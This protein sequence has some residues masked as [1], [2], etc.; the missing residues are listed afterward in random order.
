MKITME[1]PD[2]LAPAFRA[3]V[4]ELSTSLAKRL[5]LS[6]EP[7]MVRNLTQEIIVVGQLRAAV[8]ANAPQGGQP[9]AP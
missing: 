4:R 2:A 3:A 9:H 8:N 5:M 7:L 1:I 6:M